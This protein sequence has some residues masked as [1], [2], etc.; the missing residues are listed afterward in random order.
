MYFVLKKKESKKEKGNKMIF[1]SNQKHIDNWM[2]N[3]AYVRL[4]EIV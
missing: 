1:K 3:S 4:Q 2:R